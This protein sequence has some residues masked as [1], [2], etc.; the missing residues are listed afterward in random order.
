MKNRIILLVSVITIGVLGIL[1]FRSEQEKA[2]LQSELDVMNRH[3]LSLEKDIVALQND[4]AEIEKKTIKG[5][6]DEAN[7]AIVDG[8]ESFLN[9]VQRELNQVQEEIEKEFGEDSPGKQPLDDDQ[10]DQIKNT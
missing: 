3:A 7:K 4:I 2:K 5:A 1:L 10:E 8:W 9:R 6:V